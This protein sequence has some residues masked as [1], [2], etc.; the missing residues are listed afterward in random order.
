MV[1][2]TLGPPVK[3]VSRWR[4]V[5]RDLVDRLPAADGLAIQEA[6]DI[7][8]AT[9]WNVAKFAPAPSGQVSLL[10]YEDFDEP[11]PALLES[12]TV[13][14]RTG[15]ARRR[16]YRARPNPPILHRK[17][18]LLDEGDP[19]R[20]AFAALTAALEAR[21]L[22]RATRF[23]GTRSYWQ[24]R[25]AEA[26]VWIEGHALR[27]AGTAPAPPVAIQRHLA[28][29]ERQGLSLPVRALLRFGL[30]DESTS[31]FDYGCGRGSD[32]E[33]LA[34]AGIDAAGW[35]PYFA[36]AEPRVPADVVNLGFVLNVIEDRAERLAA[37]RGAFALARTCLAVSVITGTNA[38]LHMCR[39]YG[40]G[41]ITSRGTFQKFFRTDELKELLETV[42]GREAFAV[43]GGLFFVFKEDSAEQSFLAR[44]QRNARPVSAVQVRAEHGRTLEALGPDLERLWSQALECG[45]MPVRAELD[46]QFVQRLEAGAGSLNGALAVAFA[47]LDPA[48]LE[49]ARIARRDDLL[50]Y[51]ALN[52]FNR[53]TRYAELPAGLQH[54]VRVF[55]GAYAA[56]LEQS[57]ALLFSLGR[58]RV[59]ADACVAAC[60]SGLGS[61][62]DDGALLIDARL[63]SR[64]PPTLRCF[65]GCAERYYGDLGIA[66]V[67]KFHAT[68]GKLSA[69]VYSDYDTSPLP[70][71]MGRIKIDLGSQR[72]LERDHR[73]NDQRLI[74]K[75]R[76]M[77]ADQLGYARQAA[78]DTALA[79][80]GVAGVDPRATGADLAA[81]L[82]RAGC[83]LNGFELRPSVTGFSPRSSISQADRAG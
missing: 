24:H 12:I 3:T 49:N 18:L 31:V 55:F 74:M 32:V 22:F 23:I 37:L 51:F 60:Q 46:P 81:L 20:E 42:L 7:A 25:L 54:D 50:V 52:I 16:S 63:V 80:L 5:H 17:E 68:S 10:T 79:E 65:A 56:A 35:D 15:H 21:G 40:D 57:K 36:P 26:E 11:F 73:S 61:L 62:E 77:A 59:I 2:E 8:G 14:R 29:I 76:L 41:F 71:L 38:R 45:R 66:Q 27:D 48:A 70:Q 82:A 30:I 44:R 13:D 75:S 39:P 53:R 9:A 67:L 34:A 47:T 43:G 19:R 4:Y 6:E 58:P 28:A 72:I 78:F 64:L 83:N 69:L 33:G 1:A